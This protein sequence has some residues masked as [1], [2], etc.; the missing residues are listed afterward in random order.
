M[1]SEKPRPCI[2]KTLANL[3][4][5]LK[6]TD[7]GHELVREL[8]T[9]ILEERCENCRRN[10]AKLRDLELLDQTPP[11]DDGM[12]QRVIG[13]ILLEP[14]TIDT[15]ALKPEHFHDY[16]AAGVYTRMLEMRAAGQPV[17]ASL[18][19][20][21]SREH[22]GRDDLEHLGGAAYL[23]EAMYEG[24]LPSLAGYYARVITDHA[25]RR[26][27]IQVAVQMLVDAYAA[28][29]PLAEF[30]ARSRAAF[31]SVLRELEASG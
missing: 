26:A 31:D 10:P 16:R 17:D 13:M 30:A 7:T 11:S 5:W 8:S 21:W 12:E 18:L 9:S 27:L 29:M 4:R 2:P 6:D 28:D 1:E 22:H 19:V 23:A 14:T 24:G 15:L 20:T 25:M 3:R